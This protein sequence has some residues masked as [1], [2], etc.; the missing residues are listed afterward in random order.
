M[1]DEVCIIGHSKGG[2]LAI[3]SSS[4]IE[5][6]IGLTITNSCP[7]SMP[8]FSD[9]CYQDQYF[10]ETGQSNFNQSMFSIKNA[11]SGHL[12]IIR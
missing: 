11:S 8:L 3:A 2:N 1:S 10:S 5:N 9:L 12:K 4:L 7:I 6:K